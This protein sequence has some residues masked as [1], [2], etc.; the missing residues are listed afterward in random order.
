MKKERDVHTAM[1]V[2][3]G[4]SS[5]LFDRMRIKQSSHN[6]ASPSTVSLADD[7]DTYVTPQGSSFNE[8]PSSEAPSPPIPRFSTGG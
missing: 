7:L 8:Q 4:G 5:E 2:R 6:N 1:D 3:Q